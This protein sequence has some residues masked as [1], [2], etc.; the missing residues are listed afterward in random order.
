MSL[1][2]THN[3]FLFLNI[4]SFKFRLECVKYFSKINQSYFNDRLFWNLKRGLGMK[5]RNVASGWLC[6]NIVAQQNTQFFMTLLIKRKK[7]FL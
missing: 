7:I 4:F 2:Y 3:I 5:W 6:Y 1:F